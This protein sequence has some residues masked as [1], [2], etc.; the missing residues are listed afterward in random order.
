MAVVATGSHKA[1]TKLLP[2]RLSDEQVRH[3][4]GAAPVLAKDDGIGEVQL[5]IGML[6]RFLVA[7]LPAEDLELLVFGLRT[8]VVIDQHVIV[9]DVYCMLVDNNTFGIAKHAGMNPGEVTKSV[10][11]SS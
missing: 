7:L 2:D 8:Q 6:R 3:L 1:P 11:S 10:N 4:I 5:V 9:F